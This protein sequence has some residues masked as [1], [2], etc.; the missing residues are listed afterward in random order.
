MPRV[1]LEG[2][3]IGVQAD[4]RDGLATCVHSTLG[5]PHF[6]SFSLASRFEHKYVNSGLGFG[7][8]GRARQV[9]GTA[10]FV[11]TPGQ[12]ASKRQPRLV[13]SAQMHC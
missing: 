1:N 6:G 11:G 4:E 2:L 13:D 7:A 8:R 9:G 5:E 3:C 10:N 12:A